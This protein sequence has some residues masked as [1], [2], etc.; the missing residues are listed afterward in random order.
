MALAPIA[1]LLIAKAAGAAGSP[2]ALAALLARADAAYTARDEP[3]KLD[4]VD[5]LL[6]EAEKIAPGEYGVLWRQARLL[7]WKSD[8]LR[9][10]QEEKSR[11]G[12]RFNLH[13]FHKALL[14]CGTVPP[15]LAR[16]ELEDQLRA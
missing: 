13:D 12:K 11:L 15:A 16:M 8:D 2:P 3:G 7:F 9:I 6:V 5:A 4:E 10:P 14:G 1:L